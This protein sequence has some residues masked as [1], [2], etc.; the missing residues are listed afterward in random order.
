MNALSWQDASTTV[1]FSADMATI[2]DEKPVEIRRTGAGACFISFQ[3]KS[4][5]AAAAAYDPLKVDASEIEQLT[6]TV[7]DKGRSRVIPVR[8]YLPGDSSAAPIILFSHG[9][10]GSR[11]N[12]PYLGIHWAK[13]GYVA[14][15][16]QHPGSDESVWKGTRLR[17][18]MAAMRKAASGDN[19]MLRV[20]DVPTVIDQLDRWNQQDGHPLKDRLK[21]ELIGMTGHSFGAVTTQAV[22]GQSF[23]GGVSF[24][25]PRI[26][27]ALAMSPSTNKMTRPERS[28]GS[29][30][31]PWLLMTGTRDSSPI[32]DTG[33]ESRLAVY[34]ALPAGNKYELVLDQ[35]EHSAFGDRALPGERGERNPNHHRAILAISTAFWD[36]FLKDDPAA[37]EWLDGESVRQVLEPA[38]RWQKK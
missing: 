31:I 11:D 19:F 1:T 36:T 21:P 13:R 24:T 8:V 17:D 18:R 22:S 30:D 26:K 7:D 29:V 25:D 35:A 6:L 14:V 3:D 4:E 12:S 20:K 27:C 9:L 23:P 2:A 10:G 37:R 32:N 15:F 5:P 38:D 33:V 16:M 28:F 34:P